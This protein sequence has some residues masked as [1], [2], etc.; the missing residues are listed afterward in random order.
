MALDTLAVVT[1][2]LLT[3]QSIVTVLEGPLVVSVESHHL[4][5]VD[6]TPRLTVVDTID[7]LV[8]NN[9]VIPLVVSS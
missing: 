2:G 5:P 8:I 6:T 4:V 7:T 9:A 1:R 3:K